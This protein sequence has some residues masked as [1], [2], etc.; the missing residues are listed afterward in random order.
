VGFQAGG[1]TL[2]G[3]ESQVMAGL[4]ARIPL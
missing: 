2:R 4:F 3:T 1:E